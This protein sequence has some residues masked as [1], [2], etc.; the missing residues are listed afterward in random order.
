LSFIYLSQGFVIYPHR[1]TITRGEETI[2]VRPKTFALLLLMLEK[3]REVLSKSYLL[4]SVWDDVTVEE[5]V[6]VQSIRELRQLFAS[7]EIIQT[8]PR[9]GYAWSADVEKQIAACTPANAHHPINAPIVITP[10]S[11]WRNI[12]AMPTF[13]IASVITVV[14]AMGALF[15]TYTARSASIQTEVV[16]VLPVKN[17]IPSND[18]NWVPLGAMDELIHLLGSNKNAQVMSSEYVLGAMAHANLGRNFQ[19]QEVTRVFDVSGASLIVEAQIGGFADNYRIDYKLHFK[20]DIKR[21][22]VFDRDL[23]QALYQLGEIIVSYTGQP[24]H[25]PEEKAQTAFNNELFARALEKKDTGEFELART[26]FASLKQLE[27]NNMIV[28]TSLAQVLIR[29]H[30]YTAAKS[31]IESALELAQTTLAPERSELFFELAIIAKHQD[32]F[33]AALS[34]LTQAETHADE[35]NNLLMH[36]E[37]ADLRGEIYNSKGA[38]TQAQTAFE[39][40][41]KFNSAIRC[42]VGISDNHI[43]LAKLLALQGKR[44][45]AQEH[46]N[47]AKSVIETHHLDA[48]RANLAAFK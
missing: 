26:L 39:Q 21:G 5:Q 34:Y 13:V 48:M 42:P 40:A 6:L 45:N 38:Y 41:L 12:Y 29:L 7:A 36:A 18:Y 2:Q 22:V 43:K 35:A 17:Q 37:I 23:H 46:Y 10:S 8:Y 15:Y 33:D 19:T 16:I 9:K 20:Q 1:Q 11:W 28:R 4:E 30:D 3:P 25:K 32:Q 47:K 27:P 44:E 14:V 31:E 24:L